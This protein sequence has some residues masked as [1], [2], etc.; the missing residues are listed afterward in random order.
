M[1]KH[2]GSRVRAHLGMHGGEAGGGRIVERLTL[3][4]FRAEQREKRRLDRSAVRD[5]VEGARAEDGRRVLRAIEALKERGIWKKAMRAIG[6]VDDVPDEFRERFLHVWLFKGDHIRSEVG[7]DLTLLD[8]LRSLLPRYRGLALILFRGD[9]MCNRRRR[10]YG[11]SWT[12]SIEVAQQYAEGI[13]R[14][15]KGGSVLLETR[16]PP[17]AVICAPAMFD[18]RY[19]EREYI[20]DR[21]RLS[22]VKVVQ[23]FSQLDL[24]EPTSIA[25][26]PP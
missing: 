25:N 14:T 16:A 5:F 11:A 12:E 21:R 2:E 19:A 6:K 22:A 3:S 8:G 9:S 10:T 15:F 24:K 13:W 1:I 18:D 26:G 20:V 23:R 17:E 7:D 4:Q